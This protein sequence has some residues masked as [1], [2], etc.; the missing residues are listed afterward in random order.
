MG[1]WAE[2]FKQ[3]LT[4]DQWVE[5]AFAAFSD[6]AAVR[7]TSGGTL[8]VNVSAIEAQAGL[9]FGV[10]DTLGA[11]AEEAIRTACLNDLVVATFSGGKQSRVC[12]LLMA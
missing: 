3:R 10:L 5:A 11:D 7:R 4:P 6:E 12:E 1:K 2:L 8:V 9:R